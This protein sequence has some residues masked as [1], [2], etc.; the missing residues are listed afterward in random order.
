MSIRAATDALAEQF[1]FKYDNIS[2]KGEGKQA[3]RSKKEANKAEK[4]MKDKEKSSSPTSKPPSLT[5]KP[6]HTGV[7]SQPRVLVERKELQALQSER[8]SL[9]S[10]IDE[11]SVEARTLRG[12][13]SQREE[14]LAATRVSAAQQQEVW[15]RH[16]ALRVEER[17]Q[18]R[19]QA[20]V[21]ED[22][23][24]IASEARA[25]AEA[26]RARLR[27]Q[28]AVAEAESR[29]AQVEATRA[30]QQLIAAQAEARKSEETATASVAQLREE[31]GRERER[32]AA[33]LDIQCA[34]ARDAVVGIR[35]D[36]AQGRHGSPRRGRERPRFRARAAGH[37]HDRSQPCEARRRE[38]V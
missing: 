2:P 9:F 36:G 5:K 1:G 18:A 25:A 22:K 6:S 16:D 21:A 26:D 37:R 13:V 29:R 23:A 14:I 31:L 27:E 10:R 24:R 20:T 38:R 28:L 34:G 8:R 3:A 17:D 12:E 32:A 7:D 35:Q 15:A 19:N 33:A 4:P 30:T 11:A